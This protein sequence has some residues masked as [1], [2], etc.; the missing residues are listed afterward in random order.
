MI[1]QE[2]KERATRNIKKNILWIFANPGRWTE[3]LYIS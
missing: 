3:G 2:K 1:V